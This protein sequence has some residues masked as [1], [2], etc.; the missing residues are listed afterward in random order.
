MV[1]AG[2]GCAPGMG[3]KRQGR[4]AWWWGAAGEEHEWTLGGVLSGK[5]FLLEKEL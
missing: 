3:W 1:G 2:K 4:G 5:L